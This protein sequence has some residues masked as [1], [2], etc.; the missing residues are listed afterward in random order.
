[1]IAVEVLSYRHRSQ[2]AGRVGTGFD[3]PTGLDLRQPRPFAFVCFLF[4]LLFRFTA[5]L[6]QRIPDASKTSLLSNQ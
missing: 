4:V 1:M 2:A 3:F 5:T 6:S